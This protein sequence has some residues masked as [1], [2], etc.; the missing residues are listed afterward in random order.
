[1]ETD[2]PWFLF[3]EGITGFVNLFT[4]NSKKPQALV[5]NFFDKEKPLRIHD[6]MQT[7]SFV[8]HLYWSINTTKIQ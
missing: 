2:L 5:D 6:K 4:S 1:M 8:P 3:K 7:L